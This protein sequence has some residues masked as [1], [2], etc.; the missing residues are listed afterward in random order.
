M[1]EYKRTIIIKLKKENE[2]FKAVVLFPALLLAVL[3]SYGQGGTDGRTVPIQLTMPVMNIDDLGRSGSQLAHK[4]QVFYDTTYVPYWIEKYV[5]SVI[6]TSYFASLYPDVPIPSE[7][8]HIVPP[9]FS[10][11]AEA[12]VIM[13]YLSD[14]SQEKEGIVNFMILSLDRDSTLYYHVDYNNNR[15]FQDDGPPFSFNPTER[16]EVVTIVDNFKAFEFRVNN[17]TYII[18]ERYT[19]SPVDREMMWKASDRKISFWLSFSI[20]TGSGR[21]EMSYVPVEPCDTQLIKYTAKVD[22]SFDFKLRLGVAFYRFNLAVVGSYEKEETSST[23]RYMYVKTHDG[24]I[25]KLIRNN[26]G[27]WP[28]YKFHYGISLSYDIPVFR[29]FRLSPFLEVGSW[30]YTKD[31]LFLKSQDYKDRYVNHY[32]NDKLY[33]TYGLEIKFIISKTSMFYFHSGFKHSQFDASEFFLDVSPHSFNQQYDLFYF[34]AGAI[35]RF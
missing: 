17:L 30:I 26:T 19:L 20:S 28:E 25:R 4:Q 10:N 29:P 11:T 3:S 2:L 31:K 14:R 18:P 22:C 9:D 12:V 24:N 15:N 8:F 23:N 6:S 7:D 32:I 33:Y 16:Y 1:F 35:F 21:P 34:G 5:D 27:G 13:W